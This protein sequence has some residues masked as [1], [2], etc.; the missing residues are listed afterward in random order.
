M[1]GESDT[2]GRS[3]T[4]A[5]TRPEFVSRCGPTIATKYLVANWRPAV[6][7][8]LQTSECRIAFLDH[9]SCHQAAFAFRDD[10]FVGIAIAWRRAF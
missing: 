9:S 6:A 10:A 3:D 5:V 1:F 2:L 8:L 7:V 4:T